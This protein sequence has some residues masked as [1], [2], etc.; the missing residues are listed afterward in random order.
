M[1][2]NYNKRKNK[3][4]YMYLF[5][6]V[7][8]ILSII[9][10]SSC[11]AFQVSTLYKVF[12]ID[13]NNYITLT[14]D[15]TQREYIYTTLSQV[16]VTPTGDLK[17]D[18]LKPEDIAQWPVIIEPGEI[19]LNTGE[20]IRLS[21]TKNVET[22]VN[23][24]VLGI[25][26][27]PEQTQSGQ[28]KDNTGLQMAIG[29]KTWLFIP[30]SSALE[31]NVKTTRKGQQVFIENRTNKVLRVVIENCKEVN[32]EPCSGFV[33]SLPNTTK[34][35]EVNESKATLTIYTIANA[36]EKLKEVIL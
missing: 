24:R 9:L 1:L 12:D 33:F 32:T 13:N 7:I 5:K 29:Y 22:I 15:N 30:G 17:E 16:T 35:V 25:S 3:W 4:D 31:G 36:E 14:G 2:S 8:F 19:V 23:D 27:I 34:I 26:F 6:Q 11:F 20:E 28:H 21:I 10:S 18:A